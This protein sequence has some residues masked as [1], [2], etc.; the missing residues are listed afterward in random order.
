MTETLKVENPGAVLVEVKLGN[1]GQNPFRDMTMFPI[2][3]VDKVPSL[4]ES[5]QDTGVW[6]SIIARP[7]DN[8]IG[9][10]AV[11]QAE[12]ISIIQSGADLSEVVWE[13]AFGH[14]RHAA[15]EN[16]GF[17]SMPIIPQIRTDEEMLRMMANENK[18]GFGSSINS[19]LETVRQVAQQLEAS[20]QDF[21][22]F[23]EYAESNG[24]A[25]HSF[26][27]TSKQ[28]LNAQ[29]QGVGFRTVK[30]FL[31]DT[32]ND[33]DVRAPMAVLKAVEEELFHQEDIVTVPSMGL[34]EEIA[35]IARVLYEG[36]T[37]KTKDAEPVDAV[38]WP[39]LLKA[40]A[41]EEVIARCSVGPDKANTTVT[42]STLTKARQALQKEG[43]NPAS[44]LRSGKGKTAYDVYEALKKR[45]LVEDADLDVN[46]TTIDG[47]VEV[48]GLGDWDK[49]EEMQIKLRKAAERMAEGLGEDEL[50]PTT[51]GDINAELGEEGGLVE[52]G[53][54]VD[55]DGIGEDGTPMPINQLGQAVAGD[56]EIIDA[57]VSMLL[58]RIDE[59]DAD[60][61]FTLSITSLLNKVALLAMQTVGKSALTDAFKAATEE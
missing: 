61:S 11:D 3:M 21:D 1:L 37:P 60:E 9:G 10:K 8:M 27:G 46:M 26:F 52:G 20:I 28:F 49:L 50:D 22:T 38:D 19:S 32:W 18:E 13:K 12:L 40:E 42:V 56:A 43:V 59:F 24:G 45:Y 55:Y 33:R 17:E 51:E 2:D 25:A 57:R 23:E 44:Y 4:V 36:F 48:D 39:Y 41:I 47:L 58:S 30:R 34:L 29:N 16:M 15:V 54:G 7:K 31:G 6:P 5:M 14:H 53:E 35:S